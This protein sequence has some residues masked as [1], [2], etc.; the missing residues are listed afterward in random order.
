M[1]APEITLQLGARPEAVRDAGELQELA[2]EV[3]AAPPYRQDELDAARFAGRLAVRQRQPGFALAEARHGG[4]LVGFA[5]GMPLRPST[6]WW[7]EVTTPLPDDVT[8]E[9]PGRTF[10]LAELVVRAAWRRQGIGR[11][12]HDLILAGRREERATAAVLPAATAAQRA[13]REWGWQKVARTQE[14]GDPA[15]PVLDVLV[16]ALPGGRG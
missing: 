3:Y 9:R 11:D 14:P 7:R 10:A 15:G 5:L 1:P 16:R 2:A 13:A 4:Y 12:L 8:A 6:S